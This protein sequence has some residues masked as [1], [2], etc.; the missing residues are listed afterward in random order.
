MAEVDEQEAVVAWA[1]FMAGQYP[2]LELLYAI[3]NGAHLYGDAKRRAQ[4]MNNLK[5][6]G[7]KPGIPDL[8][9]PV[10]RNGWN[11]LYI[12]MKYGDNKPKEHQEAVLNRLAEEGNLAVACWSAEEAIQTII[13]YLKPETELSQPIILLR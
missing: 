12:E 13:E 1:Q 10:A 6:Q 3:P 2:E 5:K 8:C 7:L 11:A 4:Q 9:L